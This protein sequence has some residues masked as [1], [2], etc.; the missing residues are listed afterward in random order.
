MALNVVVIG[1]GLVYLATHPEFVRAWV[2]HVLAGQ[3]HIAHAEHLPTIGTGWTPIIVIGL[4]IFPKLAL[5]LS[6]FET[7]VAVMP[8]IRG[9]A[10]DTP[11][12]P[13]GRIR[14]AKKLLLTAALIMSACLLGSSAVTTMLIDPHD[15]L[16]GGGAEHRALAFIAHGQLAIGQNPKIVNPLFGELFGTIYDASTIVILG[17]AGAERHGGP[18]RLGAADPPRYGM[19]PGVGPR[20]TLAGADVHGDQSSRHLDF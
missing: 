20:D 6:G 8:L 15:M 12:N 1:S 10:D 3:W 9:D 18:A 19:A 2:D 5:G 14:N 13:R 11:E 16:H 4:L 7:G 17:F